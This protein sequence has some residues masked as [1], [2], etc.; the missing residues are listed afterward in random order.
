M[1]VA[2]APHFK[3][4]ETVPP[5]REGD[6][7]DRAEFRR[8]Y[9]AMPE[10]RAELIDGIVCMA[11][12]VRFKKHSKPHRKLSYWLERYEESTPGTDGGLDPTVELGIKDEYQPD[13]I[14]RILPEC[15]G[16]TWDTDDGYIGGAPELCAE[17]SASSASRD[18]GKKKNKYRDFGVPEVLIWLVEK[19]KIE[20]WRLEGGEYVAI[21]PDADGIL[22]SR[23][24]PGL[25][26]DPAAMLAMNSKRVR[27]I[28]ERGLNS[29]EHA[30][31]V[32][33]LAHS[34]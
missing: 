30:G 17:I 33:K 11:S 7:L 12:P 20:W 18:S 13:A 3:P 2:S 9:E 26:L 25:W 16:Q 27:E 14:Q 31:F 23:V 8:R 10:V 34:A 5:L 21:E 15:G 24:F 29:P 28:L 4:P 22:K 19:E 6:R 1:P 32:E